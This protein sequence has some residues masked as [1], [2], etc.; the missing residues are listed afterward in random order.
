MIKNQAS[1][2]VSS[3]RAILAILVCL[4]PFVAL[5]PYSFVR[6]HDNGDSTL[7]SM[8]IV[9]NA[10][11]LWESS[12]FWSWFPFQGTGVPSFS[13][14]M[15]N[16]YQI[17]FFAFLPDW[18]AYQGLVLSHGLLAGLCLHRLLRDAF[19]LDCF[20]MFPGIIDRL[21]QL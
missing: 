15:I 2:Q 8:M 20:G 17:P 4:L 6:V 5:G 10:M 13:Q 18:L 11:Y 19:S 7:P 16:L 14:G 3:R 21:D 1:S 12:G 9:A